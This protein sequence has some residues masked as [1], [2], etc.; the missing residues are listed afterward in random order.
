[1][2]TD[3]VMFLC[4]SFALVVIARRIGG[5]LFLVRHPLQPQNTLS[6][7]LMDMLDK[8]K[9]DIAHAWAGIVATPAQLQEVHEVFRSLREFQAMLDLMSLKGIDAWHG[10]L[11]RDLRIEST[12]ALRTANVTPERLQLVIADIGIEMTEEQ[13]LEVQSALQADGTTS[14]FQLEEEKQRTEAFDATFGKDL[15]P[16]LNMWKSWA[17]PQML[18]KLDMFVHGL[19]TM[20]QEQLFATI[21][22]CV[23]GKVMDAVQAP[24]SP[25]TAESMLRVSTK[26]P[27]DQVEVHPGRLTWSATPLSN[28]QD[29]RDRLA[30]EE[31]QLRLGRKLRGMREWAL[32]RTGCIAIAFAFVAVLAVGAYIFS[33]QARCCPHELSVET[34]SRWG[35]GEIGINSTSISIGENPKGGHC[36]R[37]HG[38]KCTTKCADRYYNPN[39]TSSSQDTVGP[40]ITCSS[41]WVTPK[42]NPPAGACLLDG[43][44]ESEPRAPKCGKGYC[45]RKAGH[46]GNYECICNERYPNV[47]ATANCSECND[48][49]HG[50]HCEFS[51]CDVE[52]KYDSTSAPVHDGSRCGPHGKCSLGGNDYRCHCDP[53]YLD[54]ACAFEHET[55]AYNALS[56]SL[57]NVSCMS[58]SIKRVSNAQYGLLASDTCVHRDAAQGISIAAEVARVCEGHVACALNCSSG[59]CWVW[60]DSKPPSKL[61]VDDPAV[62]HGKQYALELQC[63][64]CST[65]VCHNPDGSS[66]C[67]QHVK[68]PKNPCRIQEDGSYSCVCAPGYSGDTCTNSVCDTQP[69]LHGGHCSVEDGR[70]SYTCDCSGS[71]KG[72]TCDQSIECSPNPC[73]NAAAS[74]LRGT[75]IP[76][77]ITGHS[78]E[79]Q[80]GYSGERCEHS[81]CD[82]PSNPCLHQGVCKMFAADGTYTCECKGE[83]NGEHCDHSIACD[84]SPCQNGG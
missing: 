83:W 42:W 39:A 52:D 6:D 78:C 56:F 33:S 43:C 59:A 74:T 68:D 27:R 44:F 13:I 48:G 58:G 35:R 28:S 60:P 62:G 80:P 45:K 7:D 32:V 10:V 30:F 72:A 12:Q 65:N 17:D 23:R 82:T 2:C 75:C 38:A 71:W 24:T 19:E 76:H 5:A 69:C 34:T 55:N 9:V 29:T 36:S 40:V 57:A 15:R 63:A 51:E 3:G 64:S 49:Y 16:T 47:K 37:T 84:S 1:M 46:G 25:L 81:V 77:D 8:G 53:G 18:A 61:A 41:D 31:A 70:G 21:P 66:I 79:C 11:R 67:G 20:K 54:T 50:E 22:K 14:A 73:T 4:V 26:S